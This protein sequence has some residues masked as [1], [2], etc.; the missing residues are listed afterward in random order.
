MSTTFWIR[1]EANNNNPTTEEIISDL[2]GL[3]P[4]AIGTLIRPINQSK[5]A[6]AIG[7]LAGYQNQGTCAIALGKYSGYTNQSENSIAIGSYSGQV[8]KKLYSIALGYCAGQYNQGTDSIAIGRN[9]GQTFQHKNT[10]I[11]NA[12]GGVLNSVSTNGL[13]VRPIRGPQTY[14]NALYLNTTTGEVTYGAAGGGGGTGLPSGTEWS[15]YIFWN[16]FSSSWE[17]AGGTADNNRIHLGK[18]A[19][20]INQATN[21]IAIGAGAGQTNQGTNAIAIGANAGV[22]NQHANSIVIN[23]TGSALNSTSVNAFYVSP[24]RGPQAFSN[25]LYYNTGTNEITY[26]PTTGIPTANEWSEYLFWNS[27]SNSWAVGGGSADINR[28][29]LGQNAGS[30]NQGTNAIAIGTNAGMNN[31]HANSIILN[32][33]G[34]VLNSTS[35]NAFYVAPVRGPQM[36]SDTLYYNTSTNE[37][38]YGPNATA[39]PT[40]TQWSEYLFWNSASSSWAVG[41]GTTDNNRVHLGINAG[42]TNQSTNAIAIG[43]GAGQ[44]NQGSNAIAIGANA[45][46][47]NQHA[48]SIILNAT[49]GIL[50]SDS[51][52]AFY[53]SPVRGPQTFSNTLYFN[54]GTHEIAYGPNATTLTNGTQ[55]SEYLFWNTISWA[56]GGGPTDNNRIHLGQNAGQTNQGSNAIAI[57]ANA[58]VNN[59]HA[60]SIILNAT[61]SAL[62]SASTNAFYVSPVRGPQTFSNTLY[63]NTSTN[64]IV[65]GPNATAI[66]TATQWSEYLF[67]NTTSSSWA[68]GGGSTDNNRIHLGINAGQTNQSTNAIAIGAGAGQTNQGTNAIAI[69]ANAGASNQHAN[70]IVINATGSAL[71][72]A[73]T[74]AFYVAPV[75][76]PQTFSN[77]LYFNT[78]TN[79]I[80]Y[81]PNA[82]AIPTA[83]QWSEYLFWN[84]TSSS[85]A[86]GGGTTDNNRIHLGINAGSINQGLNAIAIGGNAGQTNQ[87]SNAI[88]IGANAGAS[89]QHANSIILNATGSALNSDSTNAFYVAPVRGP[90]TFSNTLYFN[91]STN[92]IVY[93]PNATAIPT[94]TQWSE[95][96]FWNT[97][98]SS[99]AV[100]GG[101]TDNNRIHLGINAGSINQGTNAIAIGANAGRTAQGL[102][103]VAIG[104]TAG[105]TNQGTSAIAIGNNAGQTNQSVGAIGI[106][107]FAGGNGQGVNSVALGS[108]AAS[109]NQA[110]SSVAIGQNAGAANQGQY[111]IAIGLNAGQATQPAFNICLNASG[112]AVNPTTSGFYAN[113]VRGGQ[114]GTPLVYTAGG[115]IA[116]AT[117]SLRYKENIVDLQ[118]D[119]SKIFQLQAKSFDLKSG[120][121]NRLGYI[122]EEVYKVDPSL[123]I[124]NSESQPEA[125][126]EFHMFVCLLEEVKRLKNKSFVELI[127]TNLFSTSTLITFTDSLMDHK[128]I[129]YEGS[130]IKFS[131]NGFYEIKS[132]IRVEIT[133]SGKEEV[134]SVFLKNGT[135]IPYSGAIV[136]LDYDHCPVAQFEHTTFVEIKH[137]ETDYIEIYVKLLKLVRIQPREHIPSVKVSIKQIE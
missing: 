34:S 87:G 135:N 78:S 48:N 13:Y 45:G 27:T 28:I 106:G 117:S 59:Q 105:N 10:I 2:I 91:T 108:G 55:W 86:V 100:G 137:Y 3:D 112:A 126:E 79:E 116:R 68:I 120:A 103:A 94:A 80:V 113:P 26:G 73:S 69:G 36:F 77:T 132:C 128:D 125:L 35:T 58:G 23:A 20:F 15:E 81:G 14:A 101:T 53:V 85:W 32:A 62:N 75:R 97:T 33:T 16:T 64:E 102:N 44:T 104:N 84:T 70:S 111:S 38:T 31:Q 6:I 90:Q 89:N 124:L 114:S 96:L 115:E 22:N 66:P 57:G 39:I 9:A 88:A 5:C 136:S 29:H 76:G 51:T 92:E 99:W 119:T 110:G 123:V 7:E 11:L 52:N 130:K 127:S 24:V 17:I 65:Y 40:A 21:A 49:G 118:K 47:N 74:N 107:P 121:K 46:V 67:W 93:G 56:V 8:D 82:T 95:Y 134:N 122:A 109:F 19:G 98:S 63:F 25:A 18:N 43:A 71:N 1:N 4:V 72:S 50:N 129:T 133:S 12:S 54:T 30:M 131:N 61:G 83:T 41:G 60:N 42:Q 37:I